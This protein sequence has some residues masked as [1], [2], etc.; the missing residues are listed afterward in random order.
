MEKDDQNNFRYS[1]IECDVRIYA[2]GMSK[3]DLAQVYLARNATP[4]ELSDILIYLASEDRR[5]TMEELL[6]RFLNAHRPA[7]VLHPG[8][9]LPEKILQFEEQHGVSLA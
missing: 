8:D 1:L 3:P 4:F 6:E 2:R 9:P 5:G 7:I